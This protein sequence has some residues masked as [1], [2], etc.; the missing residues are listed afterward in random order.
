MRMRKKKNCS[1]RM[2]NCGALWVREPE[3]LRGKWHE[4]FGNGNP[5]HIEIGC[6][7]GQFLTELAAQNPEQF[8]L[9]RVE[10]RQGEIVAKRY[11]FPKKFVA[12][13]SREKQLTDEQRAELAARFGRGKQGGV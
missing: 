11:S 12:I 3:A 13:R 9:G 8:K 5:V 6:G 10:T 4:L 7:K 2:E 1:Q